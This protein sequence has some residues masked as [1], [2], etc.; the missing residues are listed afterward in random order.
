MLQA[1]VDGVN[2]GL[3]AL[4]ARPW[5]YLLVRQLPRAWAMEDSPLVGDAMYFDLQ[6][7]ETDHAR[8]LRLG[9]IETSQNKIGSP[10]DQLLLYCYH[11]DPATG[12]YGAVVMNIVRIGGV[13]TMIG[14][15]ALLLLL[16]ARN[17]TVASRKTTSASTP[18]TR[19]A[20]L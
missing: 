10:V 13:M 14:I 19:G 11:Y 17:T 9:L 15:A 8:V 1:Y 5:P 18:E 7:A 3:S 2:A 16:K 6:E 12:K 4:H 20:A